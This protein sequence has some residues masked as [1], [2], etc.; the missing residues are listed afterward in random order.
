MNK[1]KALAETGWN[2]SL[3]ELSVLYVLTAGATIHF[4]DVHAM[5]A[6]AISPAIMLAL[7]LGVMTF[8]EVLWILV[9]G[10]DKVANAVGF[11]KSPLT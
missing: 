1:P 2:Q 5:I 6:M 7:L 8:V 10:M 3:V 11:R 4:L 9:V